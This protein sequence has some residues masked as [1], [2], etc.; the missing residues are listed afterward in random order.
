MLIS[1][2]KSYFN[3]YAVG[4]WIEILHLVQWVIIELFW[5]FTLAHLV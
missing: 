4:A 3:F 1:I 2:L 5:Q